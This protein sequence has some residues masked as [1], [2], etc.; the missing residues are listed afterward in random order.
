VLCVYQGH[1]AYLF[2]KENFADCD[3]QL[4]SYFEFMNAHIAGNTEVVSHFLAPGTVFNLPIYSKKPV[5]GIISRLF[6][7]FAT[8]NVSTKAYNLIH[9]ADESNNFN[10]PR[11]LSFYSLWKKVYRHNWHSTQEYKELHSSGQLDWFPLGHLRSPEVPFHQLIPSSLRKLNVT[12]RGNS[13]T[14]RRR[15][16]H[17]SEVQTV[18]GI[19]ITGQVFS[20]AYHSGDPTAGDY[21]KEMQDSR[22]CLNIRGRTPECHRFYESLDCGCIPVFIDQFMNFN[23]KSQFKG[24]KSKLQEVTWRRGHDLPFIWARDVKHFAEIYHDLIDSGPT[25]FDRLDAMQSESLEWWA[26]AKL[27]IKS[28]V[29]NST[30]I[31]QASAPEV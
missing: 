22:F 9:V 5:T 19:K 10:H 12:F 16:D 28:K 7:I 20:S 15:M 4:I 29:E 13:N 31:F 2:Y 17:F 6:D 25:G 11:L 27:H 8:Y 1:Y 23:Y 26:A 21:I 3:M 18:L 24:W 30:C 14:N